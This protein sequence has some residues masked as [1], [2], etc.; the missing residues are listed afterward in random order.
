MEII[1][2]NNQIEREVRT[3]KVKIIGVAAC[4]SEVIESAKSERIGDEIDYCVG[5][6]KYDQ[7]AAFDLEGD[8]MEPIANKGDI[9]I[10]Q[11]LDLWSKYALGQN[12][13]DNL[14][15]LQR[16]FNSNID[17]YCIFRLGNNYLMKKIGGF[18]IE[19]RVPIFE[20]L[21]P[22]H[23]NPILDSMDFYSDL[24]LVLQ[25]RKDTI[26]K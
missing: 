3:C 18:D 17:E 2:E 23:E 1:Y 19:K 15:K 24:W 21:H 20:S 8:S 13:D 14:L 22:S 5:R 7:L 6:N 9:A 11:K 16:F 12:F 4:G 25:I 10:T 26:K